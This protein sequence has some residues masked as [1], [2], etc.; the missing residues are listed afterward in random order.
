MFNILH[1]WFIAPS[2][3]TRA[4]TGGV[5]GVQR[6]TIYLSDNSDKLALKLINIC[7][8]FCFNKN[9][10]G[11]KGGGGVIYDERGS[12]GQRRRPG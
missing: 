5:S 4:A 7:I 11:R 2:H 1:T 10:S 3:P 6:W 8:G 12:C 9:G